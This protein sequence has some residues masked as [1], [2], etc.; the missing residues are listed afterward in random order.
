MAIGVNWVVYNNS[1]NVGTNPT[2]VDYIN[3]TTDSPLPTS[4]TWS[5]PVSFGFQ[6]VSANLSNVNLWANKNIIDRNTLKF[7][8]MSPKLS[9]P[10]GSVTLNFGGSGSLTGSYFYAVT[11]VTA[12]GETNLGGISSISLTAQQVNIS[13]I[14][15]DS[16][17]LAIARNIYR[18]TA[19][20][21]TYH[22]LTT[23]A[24]NTTTTFT[25]N[26]PDSNLPTIDSTTISNTTGLNFYKLKALDLDAPYIFQVDYATSAVYP[27]FETGNVDQY[28][29][30][31][32]PVTAAS[33]IIDGI[34]IS[35]SITGSKIILLK[36]QGFPGVHDPI[37]NGVYVLNH[38]S[39]TYT[40][41]RHPFFSTHFN[42]LTDVKI[43]VNG[44][45]TNADTFWALSF[46]AVDQFSPPS[47]SASFNPL[48][49]EFIASSLSSAANAISVYAY[50]LRKPTEAYVPYPT[51]SINIETNLT[52]DN[53]SDLYTVNL[54]L[55]QQG[56]NLSNNDEI[57][58]SGQT[59]TIQNGSYLVT[60][61]NSI[62]QT[63]NLSRKTSTSEFLAPGFSL[64]SGEGVN[65]G[66]SSCLFASCVPQEYLVA[67]LRLTSAENA[68]TGG[69]YTP[70]DLVYNTALIGWNSVSVCYQ[71]DT[72]TVASSFTG[73][74]SFILVTSEPY[75]G[76]YVRVGSSAIF[77]QHNP[78]PLWHMVVKYVYTQSGVYTRTDQVSSFTSG[79]VTIPVG[80]TVSY[81]NDKVVDPLGNSTNPFRVSLNTFNHYEA[82]QYTPVSGDTIAPPSP[83]IP[84]FPNAF[85]LT[86]TNPPEFNFVQWAATATP[87]ASEINTTFTIY[88][89]ESST[90]DQK[91]FYIPY[92][93]TVLKTEGAYLFNPI[94]DFRYVTYYDG[95]NY[96]WFTWEINTMT[97][98][99]TIWHPFFV[100]RNDVFGFTCKTLY[101]SDYVDI[102]DVFGNPLMLNFWNYAPI[103]SDNALTNGTFSMDVN[104][105]SYSG[106][107]LM[108]YQQP[109]N[110]N[111]HLTLN[112]TLNNSI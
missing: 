20:G 23:I 58:L 68:L 38:G 41:T 62:N 87:T 30:L 79:S 86:T 61:V 15:I 44:G 50:Q 21:S 18:T 31:G 81:L 8:D 60:N 52:T 100:F 94:Y 49:M 25:D 96:Y 67:N 66:L 101:P 84:G 73:Q 16:S 2:I 3:F 4:T 107:Y 40:L 9:A 11:F 17:G 76:Y 106:R 53:L 27:F 98:S 39:G 10:A 13:A 43:Q 74:N 91:Q 14:Q 36:N 80:Y 104:Q 33:F 72:T 32:T 7:I 111:Y 99:T 55:R 108:S 112:A 28:A 109:P 1:A 70:N 35:T 92:S 95:T 42:Y 83:A 6:A 51:C 65:K 48:N 85:V 88:Y 93:S 97:D 105:K 90:L 71:Y 89:V 45:T 102:S 103:I 54:P 47:P 63:C 78:Y 34:T 26:I 69:S 5:T 64:I 29:T 24:D 82:V 46:C 12:T 57:I 56:V 37:T 22:Y 75:G 59:N 19:G 77:K 110:G